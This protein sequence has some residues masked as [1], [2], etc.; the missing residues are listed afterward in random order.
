[1]FRKPL[2][3]DREYADYYE[4]VP[5]PPESSRAA[6]PVARARFWWLPHVIGW[7]LAVVAGLIAVR[8]AAGQPMLEK[9]AKALIAPVGLV[10][11]LTFLT[12]WLALV[13]RQL[14]VGSVALLAWGLLTAAGNSQVAA[15]LSAPLQQSWQGFELDQV[16][17]LDVVLVLGGGTSQ[18]PA[19]QAQG[20]GAADRVIVAARMMLSGKARHAVCAGSRVPGD[21]PDGSTAGEQTQQLLIA[22]Q[23]PAESTSTIGG[24]HTLGEIEAFS[25]WI[26][27]N[28]NRKGQTIGLVTS[29]WH[30]NRA[31]R[32]AEAAGLQV[33][34]VPADF[35]SLHPR[36]S[37]HLL[38]PGAANL[39]ICQQCLFEYFAA[40]LGR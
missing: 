7:S 12:G 38:V 37:P 16:Q 3:P 19:G 39:N 29:A 10:W 25:E 33:E 8:L 13:R 2:P 18:T 14:V 21:P 4:D 6:I 35:R 31:L 5:E 15:W 22:L 27:A 36:H 40:W 1:M 26:D 11:L 30:M 17:P 24:R 28:P 20:A 34:A 23:V 9:I 32:L